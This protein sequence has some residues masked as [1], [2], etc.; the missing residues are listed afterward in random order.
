MLLSYFVSDCHEN[1]GHPCFT[2]V[3]SVLRLFPNEATGLRGVLPSVL[4]LATRA[5]WG[6]S[7]ACCSWH[8]E[9]VSA[10]CCDLCESKFWFQSHELGA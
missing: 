5:F 8:T 6:E 7:C 1:L 3:I 4:V 9:T 2:G 10:V